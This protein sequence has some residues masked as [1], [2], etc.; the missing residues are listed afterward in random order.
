[1]NIKSS[2]PSSSTTRSRSKHDFEEWAIAS[3]GRVLSPLG[4]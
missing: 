4:C 2:L 3:H 1:V